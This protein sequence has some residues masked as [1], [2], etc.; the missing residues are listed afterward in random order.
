MSKFGEKQAGLGKN[1][2]VG[3]WKGKKPSWVFRGCSQL[4]FCLP[5]R[6]LLHLACDGAG[7]AL[8]LTSARGSRAMPCPL[9][10][11]AAQLSPGRARFRTLPLHSISAW[12]IL[13]P[14]S[15]L[16]PGIVSVPKKGW[17][18]PVCCLTCCLTGH[19]HQRHCQESLQAS[20]PQ[21]LTTCMQE[22]LLRVAS[23]PSVNQGTG[24]PAGGCLAPAFQEKSPE[25]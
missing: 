4:I 1:K 21:Y 23:Q 19:R 13:V 8:T 2:Q 15:C 14:S 24:T 5:C 10:P 16:G 12:E 20:R 3:Y 7:Q 17:H 11:V 6:S 22:N 18:H 9:V 25:S